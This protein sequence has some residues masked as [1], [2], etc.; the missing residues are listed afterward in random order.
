M[1][2]P[3]HLLVVDNLHDH[4]FV[5]KTLFEARGYRVSVEDSTNSALEFLANNSVD[6]IVSDINMPGRDGFDF[7]KAVKADPK[8]ANIP[9]VFLTA[10]YWT[11]E[12]RKEGL[13]YGA[14]KFVFRPLEVRA[15]VTEIEDVIPAPKR[16]GGR[17]PE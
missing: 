1:S 5:A 6:V 15:L 12:V 2:E 3:A 14:N 8:L 11:D 17:L 16:A 9:F 4:L 7:I 13:E 10:S